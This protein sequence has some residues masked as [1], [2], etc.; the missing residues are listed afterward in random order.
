MYR[1][2]T[3]VVEMRWSL[4]L[5]GALATLGALS[6]VGVRAQA[7]EGGGSPDAELTV[8]ETA[9]I[10]SSSVKTLMK[11]IRILFSEYNTTINCLAFGRERELEHGVV[12]VF[13]MDGTPVGRYNLTCR[14]NTV[15]AEQ[16][17]DQNTSRVEHTACLE[18][19]PTSE[20]EICH[21]RK[22]V[23]A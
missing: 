11:E 20:D 8:A 23:L 17:M 4:W 7:E 2:V 3:A 14:S 22:S 16:L 21:K 13:E 18:C 10:C 19:A 9:Q 15:K 5:V 6:V 1:F 12:S